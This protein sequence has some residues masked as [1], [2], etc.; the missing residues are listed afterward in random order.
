MKSNLKNENYNYWIKRAPGYSEVNKEELSG[1]QRENWCRFLEQKISKQFCTVPKGEV[2]ILDVG[3]GPAFISI[4]LTQ[5]GYQVTALDFAETM[6]KQAKINAGSLADKIQFVQGDA[7]ELPFENEYFDVVI[8]RNLTWNLENP[9]SAYKEWNRVLNKNGLLLNFDANWYRYLYDDHER[10]AYEQD[11]K[12]VAARQYDDYNIG[13]NF[14]VMERI[15]QKLPLSGVF[16]PQWDREY[17][18]E[19][20]MK[21]VHTLK[22]FGAFV[23]SEKEK[24]NYASTPLFM[25]CGIKN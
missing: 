9:K 3:A 15:A 19:L 12:N 16:R 14:D 21:E 13:D 6:I 22:D 10:K 7:Q 20:G 2:K 1:E 17:L 5:M 25:I 23:Y 8:S 24:V 11:R 4:I 18:S